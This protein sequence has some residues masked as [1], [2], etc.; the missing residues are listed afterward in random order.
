MA[1]APGHE[2][3]DVGQELLLQ[4]KSGGDGAV[5]EANTTTAMSAKD[6]EMMS[7]MKQVGFESVEWSTEDES[8]DHMMM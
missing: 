5:F 1:I 7:I 3:S 4:V 8:V 6:E 2:F